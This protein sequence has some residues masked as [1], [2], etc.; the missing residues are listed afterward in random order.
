MMTHIF[1]QIGES[2]WSQRET[3]KKIFNFSFA[4]SRDKSLEAKHQQRSLNVFKHA[5]RCSTQASLPIHFWFHSSREALWPFFPRVTCST[6]LLRLELRTA[7]RLLSQFFPLDA[8]QTLQIHYFVNITREAQ[9]SLLHCVAFSFILYEIFFSFSFRF[10]FT[11]RG[12]SGF[13]LF[14]CCRRSCEDA[15]STQLFAIKYFFG[16]LKFVSTSTVQ[17]FSL[18]SET[19]IFTK[20]R[21]ILWK[22]E[23]RVSFQQKISFNCE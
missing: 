11:S 12:D 20:W 13:V 4:Y 2:W 16:W 3:I 6:F 17:R 18:S 1:M 19:K 14:L 9:L 5:T 10:Q 7:L 15:F 21:T 22:S 8:R 23:K